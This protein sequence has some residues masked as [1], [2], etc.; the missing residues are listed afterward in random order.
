MGVI[1]DVVDS[2]AIGS[3]A[4]QRCI[5]SSTPLLGAYVSLLLFMVT[6]FARPEDW[7]PGLAS[8]PL[9]KIA[10]VLALLA[11]VLSLGQI[12]QRLPREVICLMLLIVQLFLAA[13][14]SPVWSGGAFFRT[15]NFAKVP[16]IVIVMALSVRT[17]KRLLRLLFVQ[18][19]AVAVI[20][21]A[22]IW[23][24]RLLVGRLEGIGNY[25]NP[26]DLALAIVISLPLCLALLFCSRKKIWKACW[27][28][29]MLAMTYAIFLTASRAGFIALIV[30][31]AAVLWGFGIK[32][33]RYYLV[34]LTAVVGIVLWLSSAGTLKGR[35]QGIV[36]PTSNVASAY[37]SSEA[38]QALF[39]RSIHVTMEHP[40]FGIGAGNFDS[41]SGNWHDPH[42]SYTQMSSEGGMPAFILYIVIL[43]CGFENVTAAKRR[44]GGRPK[45]KVLADALRA[46]MFGFMAGSY[47]GS[48]CYQFFPYFLIAY[49]TALLWIARK[50]AAHFREQLLVSEKTVEDTSNGDTAEIATPWHSC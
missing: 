38:R 24:S 4:V 36:D 34:A 40:L 31:T 33:R 21:A 29:A 14:L 22:A 17:E 43:W 5:A 26:N 30:M 48:D 28:V 23:K 15:L 3:G 35:L 42:N 20:S 8:V 9:A 11:F 46:S 44:A 7:I 50:S 39:W 10:G 16:L 12:R 45:L 49:T 41:I 2:S 1:A 6:Y 19:A 27:I 37:G 47:F 32:Q 18:A 13:F 25:S